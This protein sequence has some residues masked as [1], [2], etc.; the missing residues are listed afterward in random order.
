MSGNGKQSCASCHQQRL[1]F[2]D[3]KAR[4]VGSTGEM[5]PRGAMSLVNVI[6]SKALTW[7][8]PAMTSLEEQALTPMFG[9]HPVELGVTPAF[10]KI[11][12]SDP[13]YARLFPQAFPEDSDPITILNVTRA[14]ASFER[15]ILSAR[16]PYDRY[17]YGGED[18]AVSPAAKRG[19]IVF[20]SQPL[21]CF[22]CHGGFN[23]SDSR[24][25]HNIKTPTLRNVA[26]T[27]PYMHDGRYAT[28]A[29]A[30]DHETA[31]VHLSA[32]D[33]AD[34]VA[35]LESL[36]DEELLRDPRFGSPW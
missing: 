33:R 18:N 25:H 13:V 8:N 9:D 5:H 17:H 20:F 24:F 4:A 15:T 1:A 14:L 34:L 12:R 19:E 6:F 31:D 2:T 28:L 10:L 35:F 26:V 27:A 3:G 23:F 21:A 29:E 11:L 22:T 16:S 7:S 36:T 30:V 32:Q